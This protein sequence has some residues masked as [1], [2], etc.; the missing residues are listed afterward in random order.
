VRH[1]SDERWSDYVRGLSPAREAVAIERH[2]NEGCDSCNKRLRF[3]RM[4]ATDAGDEFRDEPPL[5]VVRVSQA[6]YAAWRRQYLLPKRATLAR[7]IFDSMRDPL[8]AGVRGGSLRAR[9][10]VERT[11]QWIVDLRLEP[12][13]GKRIFLTGQVLKSGKHS[14]TPADFPILLMRAD[15]LLTETVAN[16]FGEFQLQFDWEKGLRIYIDTPRRRPVEIE[17]PDFDDR[18]TAEPGD[19]SEEKGPLP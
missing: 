17:L 13:S 10:L 7:L 16:R 15:T 5:A 6:A 3:W 2:V 4:L 1:F 14:T 12:E 9:R 18:S 11:G 19:P 8:P